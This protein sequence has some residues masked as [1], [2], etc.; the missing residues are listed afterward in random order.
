MALHN[1]GSLKRATVERVSATYVVVERVR[2]LRSSGF[3][4]HRNADGSH[5]WAPMSTRNAGLPHGPAYIEPWGPQQE[6]LLERQR[7]SI[8]LHRA[9]NA[10]I[11]KVG[12]L[13]GSLG[14][15]PVVA[16]A[17]EHE[18]EARRLLQVLVEAVGHRVSQS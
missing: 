18:M 13:S 8:D 10:L 14:R 6:A 3:A 2:Y 9:T 16:V 1:L 11:E 7:L 15:Y 17:E 5:N 12:N 4:V